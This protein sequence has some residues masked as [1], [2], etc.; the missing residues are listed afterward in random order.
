[1]NIIRVWQRALIFAGSL[2]MAGQIFA[3]PAEPETTAAET[4]TGFLVFGN[5]RLPVRETIYAMG[6]GDAKNCRD[7]SIDDIFFLEGVRSAVSIR[8]TTQVHAHNKTAINLRTIKDNV[9]TPSMT[10]R[11]LMNAPAGKVYVPGLVF[12]GVELPVWVNKYLSRVQI[13]LNK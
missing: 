5:C 10:F 11:Q 8:I 3:A 13:E 6:Q 9:N 4:S 2:L 7:F 12:Q 1:M